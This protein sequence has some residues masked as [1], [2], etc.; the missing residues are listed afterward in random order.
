M[1]Y[2]SNSFFNMDT[3]ANFNERT[4]WRRNS[5]PVPPKKM[6]GSSKW[7]SPDTE[8][9]YRK[10]GNRDY[11]DDCITYVVNAYGYRSDEFDIRP[12]EFRV[13]FIGD[14]NTQGIGLPLDQMY[15]TLVCRELEKKVGRPVR[16]LNMAWAGTGSDWVSMIVHQSVEILKPDVIFLLYS[17]I[18]RRNWF[19]NPNKVYTFL[20]GQ[21]HIL[22]LDREFRA[23]LRLT[24]ESESW[25]R[26]V[27]NASA[28][29]DRL[30]IL[31]IPYFWAMQEAFPQ[32][33][34]GQYMSTDNFYPIDFDHALDWARD[35]MHFGRLTHQKYTRTIMDH[36]EARR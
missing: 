4:Y 36:Y 32:D 10:S 22:S 27:Q 13:L 21:S 16:Q 14:S 31:K 25:F 17:H 1:T 7:L 29:D 3:Y 34:I 28:V 5:I 11:S 30:R 15:T 2:D 26:F 6:I 12:D 23:L 20:P 9:N 24:N 18:H 35:N 8:V 33:F 19:V